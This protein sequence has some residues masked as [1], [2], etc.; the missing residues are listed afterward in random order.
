MLVKEDLRS[1]KNEILD[2]CLSHVIPSVECQET[3]KGKRFQEILQS[4]VFLISLFETLLI[5][6]CVFSKQFFKE[7]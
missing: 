7:K 3:V 5:S 6:V 4:Y 2:R 1:T